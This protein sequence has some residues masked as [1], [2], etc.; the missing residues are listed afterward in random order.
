VAVLEELR[1]RGTPI[2]A[3]S[4]WSAET[5][6]SQRLRFPFLGWF[7]GIVVSGEE[8]VI[9]PDRRIFERLMQRHAI[10]AEDAVFI[11]DDPGNARAASA[12]GI[13]GIHFRGPPTLRQDL[14]AVG[15]L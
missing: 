13:H 1:S 12:L 11:D 9:K 8:G 10:R 7:A 6:P 14:G 15:I 4:N 5:F 3:L 2:Y